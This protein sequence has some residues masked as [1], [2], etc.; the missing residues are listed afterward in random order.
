MKKNLEAQECKLEERRE[1]NYIE[2]RVKAEIYT[3]SVT[4][5]EEN[6]PRTDRMINMGC[7]LMLQWF[8]QLGNGNYFRAP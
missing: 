4:E 5:P 2:V 6:M 1:R 7:A 8:P 3:K